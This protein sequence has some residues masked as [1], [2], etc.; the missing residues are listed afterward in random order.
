MDD[1]LLIEDSRVQAVMYRRLLETAGH[2]VRHVATAEEAFQWCLDATPDLVV[3]DQ[4]LGDKSGLEVCRRLKG[5]MTLQVIPILVLTGSQKE[6]DHLAALH[7]GAD[8]FLSKE[9]PDEQLLAV[10][11]GLLKRALPVEAVA[12]DAE[13]RDAFLRGGRVLAI[14]DSRTYLAELEKSLAESGFHVTTATS[15]REGLELLETETFHLAIV[16]VI[17]PEMDGFEVCRR[18]RAWA[19]A[20]QKQLGLLVLSGQEN[21]EV[22]LQALGSGAD[23]FVSK[24]Q[25]ME[26]ILAHINSLIRRVRMMRHIQAI[27]Q[28]TVQQELAL[29]EAELQRQQA[30]E[31]AK[32]A[33]ARAALYEELEKVAVELKRSK[34]ELET[35]IQAAEAASRAKSE[36]LANMSHEI[37]TPMNGIVGMAEL[38]LNTKLTPQQ[39]D[40]VRLLQ[41]SSD[42]LLR[43]LNDIL[44]FSKSEAGKLELESIEF[45][46]TDCVESTVQ[47]LAVSASEKGL[48]LAC[49]IPAEVPRHVV[50]DPG[51]LRQIIVNLAGNSIKFTDQGEVVVAVTKDSETQGRVQL[52]FTVRDTGIGIADDMQHAIFEEFKQADSSTSRRFGGTGLGLAICQQLVKL[53]AGR[54]WVESQ[55][56]EGTAFHFTVSL[57]LASQA[58]KTTVPPAGLSGMRVL[59]VD[60]NE[61]NRHILREML[62]HWRQQPTTVDSGAAGLTALQQAQ[63]AGQAFQLMLLDYMMPVMDGLE[64]A[65]EVKKV[66]GD[67]APAIIMLSSASI[68][69]EG[70]VLHRLGIARQLTKPI[71]QS[72]LL[73]AM[74]EIFELRPE[75]ATDTSTVDTSKP[76]D[77]S[78]W[79]I[80]LTEDNVINQQVA[81]GFL[82]ERGHKVQVAETGVEAL[83]ATE[84]ETFDLVLMDVQ[85]PE[86]D[87]F[88]ATRAIRAREKQ[89]GNHLPII[90]MTASAMKGDRERCLENG[91]D[92]YISKPVRATELFQA[93]DTV[94]RDKPVDAAAVSSTADAPD[95]AAESTEDTGELQVMNWDA[96]LKGMQGHEDLLEELTA[97]FIQECPRMM[98]DIRNFRESPDAARKLHRA[99]HTLKGS[100]LVFAAE[101]VVEV[102]ERLER[103]GTEGKTEG[104]E[105]A[106][107]ALETEVQRLLPVLTQRCQDG[108]N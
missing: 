72:D 3:L 75:T 6:R 85:M 40:Y 64:F 84:K 31:Q 11:G 26:V 2:R 69:D 62:L 90:A 82:R 66:W 93:I 108:D 107:E 61:T 104:F 56:G 7:A 24:G 1:I 78:S 106:F 54:I 86:M 12:R 60:D 19:D 91:M 4:Y 10:I 23:D 27:N 45:D 43:L 42:S 73:N 76:D 71:K 47:T 103:M 37:R 35:A 33:A 67:D 83:D 46:L 39:R 53:M 17:M 9:S 74:L 14:D 28:K 30:E 41:Q 98:E 25:D 18:A 100:A 92:S 101:R 77:G 38:L 50:G 89:T 21:R 59:V 8:Q 15:G 13:S 48:E 65:K 34:G 94:M 70:E 97:V 95:A 36:F 51:R 80:L 58:P 96:A 105:T 32:S 49:H 57:E 29:R 87:G 52:H 16:D 81:L 68:P 79:R 99:A 88:E 44:D 5:D 102:A 63:E 20:R 55:L 22:L